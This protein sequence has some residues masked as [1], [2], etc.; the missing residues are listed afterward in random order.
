MFKRVI[1]VFLTAAISLSAF[2]TVHAYDSDISSHWAEKAFLRLEELGIINGYDDGLYR[3]DAYITRAEFFKII[4]TTASVSKNE[5]SNFADVPESAWYKN[6]VDKAYTSK[7]A[8]GYGDGTFRP[9]GYITRAEAAA[10]ICKAFGGDIED[11]ASFT[12]NGSI[13]SWAKSFVDILASAGLLSG[14]EDGTFRPD[15]YITRAEAASIFDRLAGTLYVSSADSENTSFDENVIIGASDVI[16]R[17]VVFEKDVYIGPGANGGEIRFIGC[18]LKGN[19]YAAGRGGEGVVLEDTDVKLLCVNSADSQ[20]IV[21]TGTSVASNVVIR[22]EC[23]LMEMNSDKGAERVTVY[24]ACELSGDFE[25]VILA[26]GSGFKPASGRIRRLSCSAPGTPKVDAAG[27]IDEVIAETACI[28]NGKKID[29]GQ[30]ADKLGGGDDNVQYSYT[31]ALMRGEIEEGNPGA[32]GARTDLRSEKDSVLSGINL[33]EG[34][35]K[36][37]FSPDIYEYTVAVHNSVGS[38]KIFPEAESTVEVKVNGDTVGKEGYTAS[39]FADKSEVIEFELYSELIKQKNTYT[40]TVSGYGESDTTLEGIYTDVP[41]KITKDGNSYKVKLTGDIDYSLGKVP[42]VLTATPLNSK[43]SVEI[44]GEAVTKKEYDLINYVKLDITVSVTSEDGTGTEVY[45]VTLERDEIEKISVSADVP[46]EITRDGNSYNIR[47]TG[48]LDYS[49]GKIPVT[50]TLT[51]LFAGSWVTFENTDVSEMEFDLYPEAKLNIIAELRTASYDVTEYTLTLERDRIA[52]IDNPDSEAVEALLASTEAMT[53]ENLK[54]AR[55]TDADEE[56]YDKYA[57]YLAKIAHRAEN[58]ADVLEK[59]EIIQRAIDVV[60]EY[61]GKAFRIEIE[62]YVSNKALIKN[63][64]DAEGS[65]VNLAQVINIDVDLPEGEYEMRANTSSAYWSTRTLTVQ[66]NGVTVYS[67]PNGGTFGAPSS[68]INSTNFKVV[69]EN[70]SVTT[71]GSNR[72][73]VQRTDNL[74]C[75]YIEFEMIF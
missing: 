35:L 42:V 51:P 27:E 4:N 53:K 45:S 49:E 31:L 50:L 11:A 30:N 22:S 2:C 19:I 60:N 55:I 25:D 59:Q 7:Y 15:G 65:A 46:A 56:K 64:N 41:S 6:A 21:L 63:Y 62:D 9:D 68:G 75:D 14:Y 73:T 29:A 66:L 5:G 8:S 26:G 32:G 43:S 72:L 38:I 61:D 57:S 67:K 74:F 69:S 37:A 36:P 28:I 71:E 54:K 33:S 12:D 24:A 47:L 17:N 39:D 34:T 48:T 44:D 58:A 52:E 13:P 18:T 10:A 3:P 23:N 1:S 16:F 70:V 20:N 40:V